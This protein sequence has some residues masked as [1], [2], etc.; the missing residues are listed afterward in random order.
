MKKALVFVLIVFSAAAVLGAA[1]GVR[2]LRTSHVMSMATATAAIQDT[3]LIGSCW[4]AAG[5][6]GKI[7]LYDTK[8]DGAASHLFGGTVDTGML[9]LKSRWGGLWY[10]IDSTK[11]AVP[12]SLTVVCNVDTLFTEQFMVICRWADTVAV[13]TDS[14]YT[15]R[16]D[17]D[18][19]V[20][21]VD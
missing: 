14:T 18:L 9:V 15:T 16:Y 17:V 19:K 1:N 3:T 6:T 10:T 12:C 8:S 5:V 2:R 7:K 11:S 21:T 13:E 4:D 20:W